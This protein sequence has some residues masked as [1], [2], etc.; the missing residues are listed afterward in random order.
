MSDPIKITSHV[1]RDLL[2]TADLFK[3]EQ[4]VAWEYISN[5]LQYVDPGTNPLVEVQ[6]DESNGRIV[7]SGNGR[8]MDRE[9]LD[10]EFFV[11][12]G[13]NRDRKRGRAG[14]GRFGTGKVAGLGI[15]SLI[16]ITSVRNGMRSVVELTRVAI[17]SASDG[18]AIPI[19]PLEIEM[20]TSSP[21]G[22]RV[23]IEGISI[24]MNPQRV[25]DFVERHLSRWP[26]PGAQVFVNGRACEVTE[27][28]VVRAI[29]IDPPP[30][31]KA[32][33][34][35]NTHLIIKVSRKPL[36]EFERG[37]DIFSQGV[38]LETTLAGIDGKDMSDYL[39]GEMN[40]PE[41]YED[42]SQ[43][44]AFDSSRSMSLNEQN[45][46][47]QVIYGF[48]GP[49]LEEVRRELVAEKQERAKTE[50]FKRLEKEARRIEELLNSDFS[51]YRDQLR[52]QQAKRS[53]AGIDKG[54]ASSLGAG[55][56]EDPLSLGGEISGSPLSQ[57]GA[58]GKDGDGAAHA[59]DGPPRRLNPT[60]K[61]DDQGS[62]KG[63]PEG[64]VMKK[65]N[66]RGGFGVEFTNAGAE[67]DRAQYSPENR[68]IYIN[69]DH[70]QLHTALKG[71]KVEDPVFKRLAYEVAF[72]E[73]A[74]AL[75][76]ELSRRGFVM[77]PDETI[78][79]IRSTYNRIARSGAA[80]YEE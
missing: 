13:E 72:S 17:E 62:G 52:Q 57:E 45:P 11:L 38:C 40:V 50:E 34:G 75:A 27:P 80:L 33:L 67:S 4:V 1:Q 6:I 7:V 60:L 46:L 41:L 30:E 10:Q 36:D 61:K 5:E 16:R 39:F 78:F 65:A 9:A 2:Q 70:P 32:L 55:A 66:R 31:V 77:D 28:P 59:S 23:E 22:T 58:L 25:R 74:V 19:N 42:E 3:N 79:E 21:N 26:H 18:D 37:V 53:S 29:E 54:Q 51:N 76:A 56:D 35:Q 68:I 20:P 63:K 73:Y 15:G 71:R 49:K 43:P 12:H 8:G 69:L 47:V 64:G 24:K 44:A 48:L 14:R